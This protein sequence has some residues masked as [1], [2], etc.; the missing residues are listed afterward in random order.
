MANTYRPNYDPRQDSG[1]SGAEVNDLNP[2]R[3]YRVD[4]RRL[5]AAERESANAAGTGN[6]AIEEKVNK[7][8]AAA[9]TANEFRQRAELQEPNLRG[10]VPKQRATIAGVE[11][12]T[13][14]DKQGP[15]GSTSYAR[16][17]K[18]YS[19]TFYGFS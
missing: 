4:L 15:V 9:K 6:Q 1:S 10:K 18:R 5:D 11:L 2:G 19:G 17:P 14:G 13:I 12:P 7:Y 16:G 3:S 8:L